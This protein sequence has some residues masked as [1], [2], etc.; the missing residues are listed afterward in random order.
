MSSIFRHARAVSRV[1]RA[2]ARTLATPSSSTPP[3]LHSLKQR[4]DDGLTLDDFISGD[5]DAVSERVVLGNTTQYV[6]A[7]VS[8]VSASQLTNICG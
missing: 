7:L 5:V 3:K 8:S 2:G 4:L 1:P 6:L